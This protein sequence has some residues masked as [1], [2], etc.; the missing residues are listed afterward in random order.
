MFSTHKTYDFDQISQVERLEKDLYSC[1]TPI[2]ESDK[3]KARPWAVV[4]LS[5]GL[6]L[7]SP[8]PPVSHNIRPVTMHNSLA[9]VADA[10]RQAEQ[11]TSR[12]FGCKAYNPFIYPAVLFPS[13]EHL[14]GGN[15][16]DLELYYTSPPVR[17]YTV[18]MQVLA[19]EKATPPVFA[20]WEDEEL[21]DV[22]YSV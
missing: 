11:E 7:S 8:L 15:D 1:S 22:F 16:L 13:D 21:E 20:G 10:I 9:C 5:I 4:A 19:I 6:S 12:P 2:L 18:E 17:E 14:E 3:I